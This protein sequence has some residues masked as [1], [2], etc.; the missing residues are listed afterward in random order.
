MAYSLPQSITFSGNT[1]CSDMP[2][3][4]GALRH[5]ITFERPT[6][7][8]D[9][10]GSPVA[11]W[12]VAFSVWAEE[13]TLSANKR[14]AAPKEMAVRTSTFRMRYRDGVTSDMRIIHEGAPWKILGIS[15][16]KWDGTLEVAA[17][18]IAATGVASS[19]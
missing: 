7:G 14:F 18:M 15:P 5:R 17:A 19:G 4:A 10:N 1:G 13:I 12:E 8:V 6:A 16:R 2:I 11:G 9:Q 3:N